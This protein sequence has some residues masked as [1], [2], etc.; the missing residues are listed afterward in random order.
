MRAMQKKR[1]NIGLEMVASPKVLFLDEPTSGLDSASAFSLIDRIKRISH[2]ERVTAAAVIHQP[3]HESFQFF[4]FLLLLGRTGQTV[5]FGPITNVESYFN[6][7]GYEFPYH[8]N[9]ADF[10]IDVV[11]REDIVWNQSVQDILQ[12]PEMMPEYSVRIL[13]FLSSETSYDVDI[14][15]Y[16]SSEED[17]IVA[18]S[19][20]Q[21]VSVTD[22]GDTRGYLR[23]GID[24]T[25][26][27]FVSF[28]YF[29]K[30]MIHKLSFRLKGRVKRITEPL[31]ASQQPLP[32]SP[33][34]IGHILP[35]M[36]SQLLWF[37]QRE[38]ICRLREPLNA[39]TDFSIVALTGVTVGLLSDRGRSAITSYPSQAS[40]CVIALGLI[41][42]VG[43]VSTFQRHSL[44]SGER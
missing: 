31:L 26:I 16:G 28:G 9:P 8:A 13:T 1:V 21:H 11:S 36:H 29:M 38:A 40:Y 44:F 34:G 25:L 10:I 35:R 37:L 33:Q 19:N 20:E 18:G 12:G 24:A 14:I 32:L 30:Q 15:S 5:Y 23:Q 27:G 6:Q 42:M 39:F 17:I 4:D 7:L 2:Q 41:V 3:R 22:A 43:S